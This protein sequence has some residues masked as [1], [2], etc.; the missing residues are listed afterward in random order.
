MRNEVIYDIGMNN[1]D[2]IVYYLKKGFKVVGVEA[3]PQLVKS[4]EQ[5]FEQAVAN[6]DLALENIAVAVG[7]ASD[8]IEFYVHKTS[9]VSSSLVRPDDIENYEL[10]HIGHK[11]I[12]EI[13]NTHGTPYYLKIDIEHYDVE[14]L[15]DLLSTNHRPRFISAES[16]DLNVFAALCLMG[17]DYFN[18]VNGNSVSTQYSHAMI[19][20]SKGVEDYSFPA[21]SAGP[22]GEDIST[23]WMKKEI[24]MQYLSQQGLGWKDVHATNTLPEGAFFI[25]SLDD[26][27]LSPRQNLDRIKAAIKPIIMLMPSAYI[28]GKERF[29]SWRHR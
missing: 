9:H 16:H 25:E 15:K 19:N 20:T 18:L 8:S 26:L 4:C 14:I 10:I 24:F 23:P 7:S 6:Q 1:G 28:R 13:I 21:H 29:N 27:H 22:F 3:N 12:E 17:Y 11:P 5:R 2:D